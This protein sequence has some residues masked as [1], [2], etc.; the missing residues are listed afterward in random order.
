MKKIIFLLQNSYSWNSISSLY[1]AAKCKDNFET[2]IITMPYIFNASQDDENKLY[3]EDLEIDNFLKSKN[4]PFISLGVLNKKDRINELKNIVSDKDM[5]ILS[6]MDEHRFQYS[7]NLSIED[8]SK[9]F[10]IVY[11][12][13]YGATQVNDVE[14]HTR[15]S[16]YLN[17][18]KIIADN[19]Q[20][21]SMLKEKGVNENKIINIG[22]P[23]IETLFNNRTNKGIWPLSNSKNK[24]KIIWAPHWSIIDLENN[25]W[26]N[27]LLFGT[28]LNNY[29]E[30]Y[31][32]AKNNKDTIQIVFRPHPQLKHWLYVNKK[33]NIFKEFYNK[34]SKLENVYTEFTGS[35]INSFAASDLLITDG[36]SFL[37]EYPI[38]TN[39]PVIF[40]DSQKHAPFNKLGKLSE[41]Y[42][43]RVTTFKEIE[44]LLNDQTQIKVGDSSK[45]LDEL[46]PYRNLTSQMI[47]DSL[48]K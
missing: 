29:N 9:L 40:I 48:I 12:P 21:V 34:W 32:F 31:N 35:Y 19:N 14:L 22:H 43:N 11:V 47:L 38:A 17:F 20:Y 27:T 16:Y 18:W 44:N 2:L 30:F 3:T 39:K 26:K 5:I 10:K 15:T 8:I 42:S 46:L 41:E 36:I 1:D 28:F 45:L 25:S 13:Y 4:I 23:K 33:F 7:L 24:F 6:I 37:I